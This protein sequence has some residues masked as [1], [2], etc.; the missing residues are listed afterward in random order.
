MQDRKNELEITVER[1]LVRCVEDCGGV[2]LK[3][4]PDYIRGFPDRLCLFPH[5]RTVFVETKRPVG[6]RLSPSQFVT[7]ELLRRLGAD[8][9][10]VFTK[11]EA[12]EL[13]RAM[14]Q[15]QTT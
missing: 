11:E 2:C 12:E 1:Y 5:G 8:V 7:Q 13:C 15:T 4:V 3:F 10:V 9:R 6:G 14:T